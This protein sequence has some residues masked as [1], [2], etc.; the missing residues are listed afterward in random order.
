MVRTTPEQRRRFHERHEQGETY[1][2]IGD[3]EGVSHATVRYWCRRLREGGNGRTTYRRHPAGLLTRCD[4]VVRYA[5][6][7]LRLEHPRWG[8]NR[9]RERLKKRDSVCGS[10]LPS[11]ASI[12]RYLHQW[13]RFRRRPSQ[14][15]APKRLNQPSQ[16]HQRWQ[17]DFKL[18]IA[19]SDD[20][21][22]TLHTVRDPVG[23]AALGAVLF[24]AKPVGQRTEKVSVEQA[25]STLRHCFAAW[26]TLPDEVQTDG[27]PK[28]V[29]QQ[30]TAF[31][32]PFTLWLIGLGIQHLVTRPGKPTDNA[33][34]ERC[35]RTLNDY[36]IVGNLDEDRAGLQAIL[37][38][39]IHELTFELPSRAEGCHGRPPIVAHPELCQPRRAY[40]PELE[41]A[42][43]DLKRVDAHLATL[44]WVRQVGKN[45]QITLGGRHKRV[46]VGREY[47]GQHVVV[48]FDPDDRHL[49][50]FQSDG[51]EERE[52]GRRQA[53]GL[54][55]SDLTGLADWPVGLGPQ[56]LTLPLFASEGVSRR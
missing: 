1:P 28:L 10:A 31:P 37:D 55:I 13:P 8:P 18:D 16:V 35:H 47:G 15:V 11:E 54:E 34:V 20:S 45:G 29:G 24:P 9:I 43:F 23:E 40:A 50:F 52:I 25:R 41:L 39:S 33:E 2:A 38:E 12:G 49:V 36:A 44:S 4:P 42:L 7:R 51:D 14:K 48:R 26:H 27:E 53:L 17:L 56:Q 19:L 3:S 22:V 6:L 30:A 46:S 21:L 32:T 5:I